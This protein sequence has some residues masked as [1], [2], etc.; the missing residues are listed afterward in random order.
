VTGEVYNNSNTPQTVTLVSYE[1]FYPDTNFDDKT[2]NGVL[3]PG[4]RVNDYQT[5]TVPANG[6]VNLT[7]QLPGCSTQIDLVCANVIEYLGGGN[8]YGARKLAYYHAHQ[9]NNGWCNSTGVTSW[10]GAF[11]AAAQATADKAAADAAAKAAADAAAKA[12]ADKAAADAAA[13]AAADAAAKATADKAAADA[14]AKAAADAAAKAAADKAAADAAAKAAADNA[15][16]DAAAKAAANKAAT[17]A[18]AAKD[19]ADAEAKKQADEATTAK[20]AKDA[21]DAEAKKQADEAAAAKV[22]K[23][24]ADAEAKKQADEA[25]AAKAAKDAVDAEAKKQADEAATAAKAA[26]DATEA[27]AK[28]QADEAAA[29]AKAAK[30]A[31]DAAEVAAKAAE[32]AKGADKKQAD[33]AAAAAK[34]DEAAKATEAKKQADESAAATKT[35]DEAKV[36]EN[37]AD[38]TAKEVADNGKGSNENSANDSANGKGHDPVEICHNRAHNPVIITIDDDGLGGSFNDKLA[39]HGLTETDTVPVNPSPVPGGGHEG[40]FVITDQASRDLCLAAIEDVEETCTERENQSITV[41]DD[42]TSS[43]DF[44]DPQ[45]NGNSANDS[46]NGNG[47][48]PVAIC[49]NVPHNPHVI[50][51]DD[52]ALQA[53]LKHLGGTDFVVATDADR[54][55]CGDGR[56]YS[57]GT[58][59]PWAASFKGGF[60]NADTS[61]CSYLPKA[62]QDKNGN[63][64]KGWTMPQWIP[65]TAWLETDNAKKGEKTGGLKVKV[66]SLENVKFCP[67]G[68]M[69]TGSCTPEEATSEQEFTSDANGRVDFI[70]MAWWPGVPK[71]ALLANGNSGKVE[72]LYRVTVKGG[73]TGEDVLKGSLSKDLLWTSA[74]MNQGC[75]LTYSGP[76]SHRNTR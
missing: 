62:L 26:S 8:L 20:A 61:V 51:I 42:N 76:G 60:Y 45:G 6:H 63:N 18:K 40:D 39:G 47:H 53:H 16:A 17:D 31:Q 30:D 57:C 55:K 12:A 29:A 41:A 32:E 10:N 38:K 22:A 5:V 74:M 70:V 48:Q 44:V 4:Q 19:A 65:V 21:A 14:D 58:P 71:D 66:S 37:A 27:N 7:A 52:S 15:A 23:D 24:A 28:K 2:V 36:G 49:H 54:A 75:T 46:A 43:V 67:A 25:V 69:T 3:V 68:A 56:V 35:A 33:E 64:M 1:E 72:N 34:A 9:P 59:S 50:V 11:E 73:E 13:K